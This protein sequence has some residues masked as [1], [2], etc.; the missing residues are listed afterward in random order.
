MILGSG[1]L[2]GKPLRGCLSL[3]SAAFWGRVL[4]DY[5]LSSTTMLYPAVMVAAQEVFLDRPLNFGHA[6]RLDENGATARRPQA[7][8]APHFP[9]RHS[10]VLDLLE[11]STNEQLRSR[12]TLQ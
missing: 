2:A 12:Y 3:F 9:N 7:A 1:T 4:Q 10:Q 11:L 5:T 8:D 6:D